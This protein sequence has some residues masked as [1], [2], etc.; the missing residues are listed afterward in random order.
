MK[1]IE[2]RFWEKVKKTGTCWLWLG[3]KITGY[4]QLRVARKN[5]PAH[6]ISYEMH[7]GKIPKGLTIDH[8]C[9]IRHCVNPKHLEAVTQRENTM[10]SDNIVAVNARKTNCVRGHKFTPKNTYKWNGKRCCRECRT[11]TGKQWFLRNPEYL[12]NW[13]LKRKERV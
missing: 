8:L 11:E 3:C 2:Q 10:R 4:G 9:H 13:R 1:T 7:N 12:K 6:R 5:K